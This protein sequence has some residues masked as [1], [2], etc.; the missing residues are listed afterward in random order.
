MT[1]HF[2]FD[3][4]WVRRVE[5]LREADSI[6]IDPHKLGYIPYPAGA[7]LYKDWRSRLTIKFDA[8][9][10]SNGDMQKSTEVFLGQWTLEGSR[11]G[12]AAVSCFFS[13]K[14]LPL[15]RQN[16]GRLL[17]CT[18]LSAAKLYAAMERGLEEVPA[19]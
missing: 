16:H 13:G 5:C 18:V 7:V 14:V 8:P 3:R 17:A 2:N 4:T 19:H 12:A 1:D 15:D 10:V 9:Y 11:P 6:T